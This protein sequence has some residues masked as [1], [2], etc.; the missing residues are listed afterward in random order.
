[1]PTLTIRNLEPDVQHFLKIQAAQHNRSMEAEV[2]AVLKG[3]MLDNTRTPA[4]IAKKI[5]ARFEHLAVDDLQ[6]PE[7]SLMPEPPVFD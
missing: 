5:R 2:R 7:R 4:S 6:I 3:V 1:M